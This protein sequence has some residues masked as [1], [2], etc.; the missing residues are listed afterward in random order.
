MKK[1]LFFVIIAALLLCGCFVSCNKSGND[2]PLTEGESTG[3]IE[4][5]VTPEPDAVF[6]VSELYKYTAIRFDDA[7]SSEKKLF[8]EFLSELNVALG[9]KIESKSDFLFKNEQAAELEIL[10]GETV[11]EESA[12]IYKELKYNDYVITVVGSKIVIAGGSDESLASAADKFLSFIKDGKLTIPSS[13]F[14]YNAEYRYPE[15]KLDGVSISEYRVIYGVSSQLETANVI[16][17]AVGK[18]SGVR[19]SVLAHTKSEKAEREIVVG[20]T[21][22]YKHESCPYYSYNAFSETNSIYI[23][24]Y[25]QYALT[26]AAYAMAE[27]IETLGGEL[28][29]EDLCVSYERPDYTEYIE[30]IDKLYMRWGR[31]WQP[32]EKMLDYEAKLDAF[33]NVS[34]RLLTCAHRAECYYYPENSIESIISFYKMGGDVVELDIQ[35]TADGVLILMHDTNLKRMTN[36][37]DFAGLTV[38][39]IE[40]PESNAV[41]AWTYEQLQ[42]LNL[43]DGEG[44]SG[45]ALTPFKIPTLVEA[46]KV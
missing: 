29:L 31:I 13:R 8:T 20:T 22:R 30:D 24:A 32:D 23:N 10:F 11:R 25:D 3:D 38:D 28:T 34:N 45:A 37:E 9:V 44:G 5:E 6:N 2:A 39:G 18:A 17:D 26:E 27:K 46:L 40:F 41:G 36:W 14:E 4:A 42:Y 15:M 7:T 21:N 1:S 16:R 12:E 35:A 19:L 33:R 43:K